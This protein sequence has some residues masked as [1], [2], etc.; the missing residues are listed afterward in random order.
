MT[1]EQR[2]E[3]ESKMMEVKEEKN[4]QA[5]QKEALQKK[6]AAMEAKL[7]VG[8]QLMDKAARQVR[9]RKKEREITYIC[10]DMHDR[11]EEEAGRGKEGEGEGDKETVCVSAGGGGG[12]GWL[13]EIVP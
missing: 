1:E 6:L 12:G 7:L 4:R 8:G 9:R 10:N 5:R 11:Y 13:G 3:A 2:Q